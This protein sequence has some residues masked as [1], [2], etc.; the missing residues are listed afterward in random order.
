M[1]TFPTFGISVR[2]MGHVPLILGLFL[3]TIEEFL[4]HKECVMD[5]VLILYYYC[6]MITINLFEKT[7][8]QSLNTK[9]FYFFSSLLLCLSSIAITI[10]SLFILL[11]E[12]NF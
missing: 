4:S 2:H 1:K 12:I 5:I 8:M 7:L 11:F 9:L 6:K 10:L 3:D